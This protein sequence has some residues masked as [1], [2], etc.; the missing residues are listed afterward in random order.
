MRIQKCELTNI[1]CN[2]F[3]FTD[4]FL[5][6]HHQV[7]FCP[8]IVNYFWITLSVAALNTTASFILLALP[9]AFNQLLFYILFSVPLLH[10]NML[11]TLKANIYCSLTLNLLLPSNLFSNEICHSHY[12]RLKHLHF[13]LL[14]L[15]Y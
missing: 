14:S 8:D 5:F 11:L 7:N 12:N 9:I 15:L 4:V 13:D 2:I 3:L 10:V 6:V 1:F